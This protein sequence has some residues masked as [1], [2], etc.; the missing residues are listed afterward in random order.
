MLKSIAKLLDCFMQYYCTLAAEDGELG[1]T[2]PKLDAI[3]WK[4]LEKVW[5]WMTKYEI[6]Y[7]ICKNRS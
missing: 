5:K 6:D 1:L 2:L 7:E 3:W 4:W